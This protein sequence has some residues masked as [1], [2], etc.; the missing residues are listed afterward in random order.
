M[1]FTPGLVEFLCCL[2]KLKSKKS[3]VTFE[4]CI[5]KKVKPAINN[6]YY[7]SLA[8]G[9]GGDWKKYALIALDLFCTGQVK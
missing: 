2:Y 1:V 8:V 9:F 5:R 3:G 4:I 7:Y 6:N